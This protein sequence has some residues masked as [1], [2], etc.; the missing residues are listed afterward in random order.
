MQ[1]LLRAY[2][3]K[4]GGLKWVVRLGFPHA[5]RASCPKMFFVEGSF[6][7]CLC[8]PEKVASKIAKQFLCI[9]G[10]PGQ[11]HFCA[12]TLPT[13]GFFIKIIS[14]LK[15]SLFFVY[16]LNLFTL[17][18]ISFSIKKTV[19]IKRPDSSCFSLLN[20]NNNVLSL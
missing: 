9:V 17:Y 12:I 8:I 7:C 14:N 5:S 2:M 16:M 6:A 13:L 1:N 10:Y 4:M 15:F 20:N 19:N 3:Q 18:S 11:V